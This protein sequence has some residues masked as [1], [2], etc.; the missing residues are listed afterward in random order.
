[1]MVAK[2]RR[3]REDGFVLFRQLDAVCRLHI[4][5][6]RLERR[7]ERQ[8]VA[9]VA[10]AI[11]ALPVLHDQTGHGIVPV[12]SARHHRLRLRAIRPVG[13]TAADGTVQP[14]SGPMHRN[15]LRIVVRDRPC[16]TRPRQ[17]KPE[18][19]F[20][21]HPVAGDLPSEIHFRTTAFPVR[22]ANHQIHADGFRRFGADS[23]LRQAR[24]ENISHACAARHDLELR[25]HD[26][27]FF[28][29]DV[30][31]H[32]HQ[33][34][35]NHIHKRLIVF[36]LQRLSVF[37][38]TRLLL[39]TAEDVHGNDFIRLRERRVLPFGG[40][41][42]MEVEP[43]VVAVHEIVRRLVFTG[44]V[45]VHELPRDIDVLLVM[46]EHDHAVEAVAC[47][48]PRAD[49]FRAARDRRRLPPPFIQIAVHRDAF[50]R[51]P[52]RLVFTLRL[53]DFLLLHA[54]LLCLE[55]RDRMQ[56]KSLSVLRRHARLRMDRI[57]CLQRTVQRRPL[58]FDFTLFIRRKSERRDHTAGRRLPV[59]VHPNLHGNSY[60]LV[61]LV[62]RNDFEQNA[63]I[64]H[65]RFLDAVDGQFH[66]VP[67]VNGRQKAP[68]GQATNQQQAENQ[69]V[70]LHIV[71]LMGH[72][73]SAF[74]G[75]P[76]DDRHNDDNDANDNRHHG[77]RAFLRRCSPRGD[78][79]M[80][81]LD[82]L[83]ADREHGR[84]LF[85]RQRQFRLRFVN[86]LRLRCF[87]Y[88]KHGIQRTP[89]TV[90]V[91]QIMPRQPPVVQHRLQF[92]HGHD[93]P[94]RRHAFTVYPH[95]FAS[96]AIHCGLLFHTTIVSFS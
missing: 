60:R 27:R 28:A 35:F 74:H 72:S 65:D 88:L 76:D 24:L 82:S 23:R 4:A 64:K 87:R 39:R 42:A 48:L 40:F 58:E 17:P 45:V 34:L 86:M 63:F 38:Q 43:Q 26:N 79:S 84:Q 59:V 52:R 47:D 94:F 16:A 66:A 61:A 71:F 53:R 29:G 83:A 68:A 3:E 20:R 15:R 54:R 67:L 69:T 89:S 13:D 73:P 70:V 55:H 18:I 8:G 56:F 81:R 51:Q 57:P 90:M 95:H 93:G 91:N 92:P 78:H 22:V 19:P 80:A 46:Q 11:D 37:V 10:V 1:M 96:L 44:D 21:C 30:F 62:L 25:R 41:H 31:R 5:R 77:G 33:R 9:E 6:T 2:R 50:H 85:Q 14:D 36:V 49:A 32:L 12:E 7:M 75:Q